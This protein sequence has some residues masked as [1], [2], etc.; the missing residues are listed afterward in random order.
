VSLTL[1]RSNP[2]LERLEAYASRSADLHR[3]NLACADQLVDRRPT[4]SE[5]FSHLLNTKEES[6]RG[7]VDR[8]V[9][10][11]IL[12]GFTQRVIVLRFE[13][14]PC[15]NPTEEVSDGGYVRREVRTRSALHAP[16]LLNARTSRTRPSSAAKPSRPMSLVLIRRACSGFQFADLPGDELSDGFDSHR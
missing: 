9:W 15:A 13:D 2:T 14:D 7:Q 5:R 6:S 11:R 8:A 16:M 10:R 4:N 3:R 12:S 1:L